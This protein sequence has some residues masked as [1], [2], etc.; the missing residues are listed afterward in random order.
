MRSEACRRT[1]QLVRASCSVPPEVFIGFKSER[2]TNGRGGGGEEEGGDGSGITCASRA[3]SPQFCSGARISLC[4]GEAE[5]SDGL[6]SVL[7]NAL[8]ELEYDAQ[9]E[10]R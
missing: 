5:Q 6:C 1:L 8:T 7:R 2:E 3:Q 9:V 10:L 4:G